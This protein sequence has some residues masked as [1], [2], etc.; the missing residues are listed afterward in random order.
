MKKKLKL[1]SLSCLINI[2][3]FAQEPSKLNVDDAIRMA[4]E[5]NFDLARTANGLGIDAVEY[6]SKF[7]ES[8]VKD[9]AFLAELKRR[10]AGE[11]VCSL[12]IMVDGEGQLGAGPSGHVPAQV[13]G[14]PVDGRGGGRRC[15]RPA[16]AQNP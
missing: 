4:V 13:H 7:Y 10:A 2:L 15:V 11:G 6:S 14:V 5:K 1:L 3:A 8:K 16:V 9:R 12:L